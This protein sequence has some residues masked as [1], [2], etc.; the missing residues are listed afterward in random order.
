MSWRSTGPTHGL[1]GSLWATACLLIAAAAYGQSASFKSLAGSWSGAG[2]VRL[3]EGGSE[4]IKC[5]AIYELADHS[6]VT[7]RLTCA[8]D[9][10]KI[11]LSGSMQ[12][13]DGAIT[14]SWS[15]STRKVEGTLSGR[16]RDN[17]II[18][19]TAGVIPATL[20]LTTTDARQSALLQPEGA[21]V[22]SVSIT[23]TRDEKTGN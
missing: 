21:K 14:G 18:L 22:R 1:V 23:M 10:Y 4:R 20:T 11:A 12:D 19:K 16:V 13:R 2:I 5:R 15:E 17:Q 7:L 6:T 3:T 8:S 9:T